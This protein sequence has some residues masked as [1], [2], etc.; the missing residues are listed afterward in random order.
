M[1][2]LEGKWEIEAN[3]PF[4]LLKMVATMHVSED[5]KAFEGSVLWNGKE[6][7]LENGTIDGNTIRYEIAMQFGLIPMRFNLEGTFNQEDWTCQGIAKAMKM[8][9]AYTGHKILD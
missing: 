2:A 3:S 5:E 1:H 6:S 7:K 8:E 4:G 9:C